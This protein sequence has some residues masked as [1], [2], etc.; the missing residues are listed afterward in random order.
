M[1]L[2]AKEESRAD[3]VLSLMLP[4]SVIAQLKTGSR[5]CATQFKEA[6]AG[7]RLTLD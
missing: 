4:K 1:A 3:W 6:S 7:C 5:H 2:L